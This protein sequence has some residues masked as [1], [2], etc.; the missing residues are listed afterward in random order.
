MVDHPASM[1]QA[2]IALHK[3]LVSNVKPRVNDELFQLVNTVKLEDVGLHNLTA[4][5]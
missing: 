4:V 5:K 1:K 2:A 3:S